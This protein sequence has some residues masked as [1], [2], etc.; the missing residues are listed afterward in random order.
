M[1]TIME[2]CELADP[3]HDVIALCEDESYLMM[4]FDIYSTV[5]TGHNII[6]VVCD[7]G[8]FSVINRLQKFKDVK[9]INNQL[10]D[11]RIKDLVKVNFAAHAASMGALTR[12]VESIV[13]L[14]AALKW[15]KTTD[16][17]TVICVS[18]NA[19]VWSSGDA[20]WDVVVPKVSEREKSALPRLI[21]CRAAKCNA[22]AYKR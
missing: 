9:S 3:S 2:C 16:R 8:S 5:L 14:E 1:I 21:I 7:N 19:Y 6:L 20:W 11:F 4:N 18:T 17:T 22:L 12:N 10:E 15:A 13:D